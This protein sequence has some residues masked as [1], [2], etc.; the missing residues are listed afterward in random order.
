MTEPRQVVN[1]TNQRLDVNI[2][3]KGQHSPVELGPTIRASGWRGGTFVTY[4][5]PNAPTIVPMGNTG[6]MLGIVEISTGV[7]TCGFLLYASTTNISDDPEFMSSYAPEQTGVASVCRNLGKYK[8]WFYETQPVAY[9]T[10][11]TG[12]ATLTYALNG[13]LYVSSDGLLTCEQETI[14]GKS[15]QAVG[16]CFHTPQ[17]EVLHA[18]LNVGAYVGLDVSINP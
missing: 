2:L 14:G 9:R 7:S 15:A 11:G 4:A 1:F 8:F 6:K 12:P 18:G 17:T 13:T 10:A 5:G 3:Q 16:K